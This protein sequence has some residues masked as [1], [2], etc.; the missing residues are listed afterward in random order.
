MLVYGQLYSLFSMKTLFT[1]SMLIFAGGSVL[2]AAAPTAPAF[3]VGRA[4]SG[5]AAAGILA[6]MNM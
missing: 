5:L 1:T 3:I 6:G 2:S 4:L